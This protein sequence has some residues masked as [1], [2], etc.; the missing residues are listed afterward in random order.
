MNSCQPDNKDVTT[1]HNISAQDT[2]LENTSAMNTSFFSQSKIKHSGKDYTG[3]QSF[4]E[5]AS[6]SQSTNICLSPIYRFEDDISGRTNN[7][8]NN[9]S[10]PLWSFAKKAPSMKQVFRNLEKVHKQTIFLLKCVCDNFLFL[11]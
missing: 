10:D 11:N 9:T 7:D 8:E 6:Q 4:Y 2:S 5:Y 1:D 3:I